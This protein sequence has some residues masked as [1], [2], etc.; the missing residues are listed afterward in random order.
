MEE[1]FKDYA[2]IYYGGE[3]SSASKVRLWWRR[4]TI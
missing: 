1:R 2:N 3:D 4:R